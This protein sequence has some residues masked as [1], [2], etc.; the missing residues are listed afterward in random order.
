MA[1]ALTE[2]EFYIPVKTVSELNRRD[3]WR[4]KDRRRREQQE[5]AYY[6]YRGAAKGARVAL[7]CVVRFVRI[8]PR[9]LD[10]DN[11]ASAMKGIRD[12]VAQCI[13]V[14]DGAEQIRFEYDQCAIGERSYNV[15]VQVRSLGVLNA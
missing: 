15:K 10:S 7:P 14:D 3:H 6:A 13:G 9:K 2:L 11:L 5:A 4:T 1:D 12:T 8:G